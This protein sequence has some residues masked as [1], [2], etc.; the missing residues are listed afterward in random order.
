[1]IVLVSVVLKRPI[2]G[3]PDRRFDS[4]SGSR[5]RL[6]TASVIKIFSNLKL[7]DLSHNILLYTV[8]TIVTQ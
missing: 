7:H 3:D 1:M 6:V 8:I 5:E 4:L 2:V